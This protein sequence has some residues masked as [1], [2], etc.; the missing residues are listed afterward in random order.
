MIIYYIGSIFWCLGNLQVGGFFG[1]DGIWSYCIFWRNWVRDVFGLS[2]LIGVVNYRCYILYVVL[3]CGRSFAD[4]PKVMPIVCYFIP[5]VA[6]PLVA[7]LQPDIVLLAPKDGYVC[8]SYSWFKRAFG[9]IVL[10]SIILACYLSYLVRNIR[11]AFNQHRLHVYGLALILID[12]VVTNVLRHGSLE[13]HLTSKLVVFFFNLITVNVYFWHLIGGAIRGCLFHREAYLQQFVNDLMSENT[14]AQSM[15][16]VSADQ[17]AKHEPL[18][19][20]NEAVSSPV[21]VDTHVPVRQHRRSVSQC[22]IAA[23]P[24]VAHPYRFPS[25]NSRSEPDFRSAL[26]STGVYAGR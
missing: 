25:L 17:H 16:P 23:P 18:Y 14:G 5:Y 1:F 8:A 2:V 13:F 11:Q 3:V 7:L 12:Y 26:V 6:L 4:A 21:A 15:G 22:E 10:S 20:A 9:F 24:P 19:R